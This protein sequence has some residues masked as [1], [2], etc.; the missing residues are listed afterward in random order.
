MRIQGTKWKDPHPSKQKNHLKVRT[1]RR[2]SSSQTPSCC[3]K[4]IKEGK[5]RNQDFLK[6]GQ[7]ELVATNAPV[8]RSVHWM[9]CVFSFD[10]RWGSS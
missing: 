10:I 2:T 5:G 6:G 8:G 7:S 3:K 1:T 4:H 9:G